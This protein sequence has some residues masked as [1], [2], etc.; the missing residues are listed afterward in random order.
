MVK[1]KR[2]VVMTKEE[3]AKYLID[4]YGVVGF[5]G[6]LID[7]NII[8]APMKFKQT[9][10]LN[11]VSKS[12][13]PNGSFRNREYTVEVDEE[14]TEDTVLPI[15]IERRDFGNELTYSRYEYVRIKDIKEESSTLFYIENDDKSLTLI[16]RDGKLVE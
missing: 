16:W 11:P 8:D 15:L 2:K 3:Y 5:E 13:L 7:D 10:E 4:K 9:F 6:E 12:D 1:I 14:I